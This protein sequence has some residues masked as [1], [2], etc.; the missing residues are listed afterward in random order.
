MA[1][2]NG[3]V[4]TE[5]FIFEKYWDTLDANYEGEN[6]SLIKA[7][8]PLKQLSGG[9]RYNI[10]ID[11][12]G[13]IFRKGISGYNGF[14]EQLN[15]FG[16]APDIIELPSKNILISGYNGGHLLIRGHTDSTVK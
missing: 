1:N 8:L 15:V 7:M 5:S 4:L 3:I 16:A 12:A 14:L 2:E 13:Q 6:D 9:S 10:F 11:G